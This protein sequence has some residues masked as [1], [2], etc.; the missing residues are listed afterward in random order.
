MITETDAVDEDGSDSFTYWP[1]LT[2]VAQA[3]HRARTLSMFAELSFLAG[4]N[5]DA[6]DDWRADML[7]AVD[8]A[9]PTLRP[10]R[11]EAVKT[12]LEAA[13]YAGHDLA[14]INEAQRPERAM[15]FAKAKATLHELHYDGEDGARTSALEARATAYLLAHK[16]PIGADEAAA[17]A[18]AAYREAGFDV[19]EREVGFVLE[20]ACNGVEEREAWE[21]AKRQYHGKEESLFDTILGEALA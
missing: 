1:V 3:E 5:G 8:K 10:D 20:G 11:R 18:V 16:L 15:K 6:T 17:C 21:A 19:P 14:A 7:A 2:T 12:L 4:R 13:F 9:F